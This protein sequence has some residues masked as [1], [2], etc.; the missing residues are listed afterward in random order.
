MRQNRKFRESSTRH[1]A[2]AKQWWCC[3]LAVRCV[4]PGSDLNF[5]TPTPRPSS[6]PTIF[7]QSNNSSLPPATAFQVYEVVNVLLKFYLFINL[8]HSKVFNSIRLATFKFKFCF[9]QLE[10]KSY[11]LST[12]MFKF[13]LL[14]KIIRDLLITIL[15]VAYLVTEQK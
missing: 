13:S 11:L 1:E 12:S 14:N 8:W 10:L 4:K 3:V 2:P 15:H 9:I 5:W 6:R 7:P